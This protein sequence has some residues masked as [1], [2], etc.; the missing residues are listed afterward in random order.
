MN[1]N[2]ILK[3]ST[4]IKIIDKAEDLHA[5]LG[6]MVVQEGIPFERLNRIVSQI[7]GIVLVMQIISK[8]RMCYE[9]EYR[10]VV[11][12]MDASRKLVAEYKC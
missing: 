9:A 11:T 4:V 6:I 5:Y 1:K 2:T 12:V 10:F 3:H 8:D 7:E